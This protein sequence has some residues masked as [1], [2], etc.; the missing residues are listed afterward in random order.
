MQ[1]E[2]GGFGLRQTRP[3]RPWIVRMARDDTDRSVGLED[4]EPRFLGP[5]NAMGTQRRGELLVVDPLLAES[6]FQ[7]PAVTDEHPRLALDSPPDPSRALEDGPERP[8]QDDERRTSSGA[9]GAVAAL[10]APVA[11][12]TPP[13]GSAGDPTAGDEGDGRPLRRRGD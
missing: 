1:A 7:D 13:A 3:P 4:D 11:L 2:I 8:I 12:P 9:S 5:G 10:G 6:P